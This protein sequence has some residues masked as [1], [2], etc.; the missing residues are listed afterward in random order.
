VGGA[1]NARKRLE[2]NFKKTLDKYCQKGYKVDG[3]GGR[4]EKISSKRRR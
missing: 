2:E 1:E 3:W 4:L